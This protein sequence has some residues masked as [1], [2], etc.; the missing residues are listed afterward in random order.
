MPMQSGSS[1]GG[2]FPGLALVAW[3]MF[4]NGVVV[5]GSG[6]SAVT[7]PTGLAGVVAT[8]ATPLA[9]TNAMVLVSTSN[10]TSCQPSVASTTSIQAAKYVGG[11]SANFVAGETTYMAVY[12]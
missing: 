7:N 11:A 8:L 10:S 3:G 1:G 2:P 4:V 6:F 12:N 9:S 5:K